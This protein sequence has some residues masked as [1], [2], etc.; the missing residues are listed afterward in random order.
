MG[1]GVKAGRDQ[2]VLIVGGGFA[3]FWAA[4]AAR[5]VGGP[6][7]P[8]TLVAPGPTLVMR[9][10]LYEAEPETLGVELPPLLDE[11]GV[12][13]Q[14]DTAVDVD[15]GART[16]RLAS[17]QT[18]RY[19][20]L[21][22]A[23]GSVMARPPVPGADEVHSIDTRDE[24]VAF[25]RHLARIARDHRDGGVPMLAVVGAGFT[26]IE[27][28][29][30]LRDRLAAHGDEALGQR[31]RIVLID[32]TAE[33]GHDLGPNPR[34]VIEDALRA[35]RVEL[36]LAVAVTSLGAGHVGFAGGE[37]LDAD[38]VVLATGLRAAPLASRLEGDRDEVGRVVVHEFLRAPQAPGVFVTGDSAAADTGDGHR[39]LT[40][41]QH[42]L[43]LGR[44]AGENA[45]RD[46]AGHPLVPYE[47]LRYVTCLDLG[48]AG[49]VF[50]EGWD[51]TVAV[52]GEQAKQRKLFVNRQLIYPGTSA[53]DLIRQS[54]LDPAAR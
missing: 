46:L 50:T 43:Q 54:N 13:F 6:D 5:R 14:Q 29:L 12:R 25:D 35:A 15:A 1:D 18:A 21:V 23:T 51:R 8:I 41:C 4:A 17:G 52:T 30:E 45:A 2:G 32:R 16:V 7:L 49:A 33:V 39:A 24:A 36:R 42:A 20:R 27:L 53:E 26:G 34:P 22:L 44:V 38:A 37:T 19:G 28:A 9:P 48:R 47:Q 31:A 40:S 10:R 3:G 11:L